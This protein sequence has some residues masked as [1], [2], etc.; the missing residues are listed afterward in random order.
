MALRIFDT[1]PEAAAKAKS[2]STFDDGTIGRL[3]NGKSVDGEPVALDHWEISTGDADTANALAELFRCE[4]V[5]TRSEAENFLRIE[6]TQTETLEVIISGPDALTSDMKLWANGNLFHHCD[7]EFHLSPEDVA[8]T[9]CGCPRLFADRK[10]MAKAGRGPKP[11]IKLIVSLA[12]DPSLGT[13][14]FRTGSW[15]MAEDLWKYEDAFARINGPMVADL[16]LELVEYVTKKGREVSYR[17]PVI[18][19]IRPYDDANAE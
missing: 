12:V 9:P 10:G 4:V 16:R 17:K 19:R 5:D 18:E 3:H 7:G 2:K 11:D 8:G 15:T 1:D 6:D 13:F 14:A